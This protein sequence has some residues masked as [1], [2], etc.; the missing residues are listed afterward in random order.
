MGACACESTPSFVG[1]RVRFYLCRPL[2]AKAG[3]A[4]L[5]LDVKVYVHSTAPFARMYFGSSMSFNR[6]LRLFAQADPQ[7]LRRLEEHMRQFPTN[8]PRVH[9][10]GSVRARYEPPNSWKLSDHSLLPCRRKMHNGRPTQEVEWEANESQ[11]LP[12][13]SEEAIFDALGLSYVP[14]A[15][16]NL[17][18]R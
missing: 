15:M 9:S 10:D 6:A 13:D 17:E 11:A 14:Y 18:K 16:R 3:N 7:A 5:R 4:Q 12:C 8:A 1:A 2:T